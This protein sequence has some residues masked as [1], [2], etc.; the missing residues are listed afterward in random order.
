VTKK[1]RRTLEQI[2][3]ALPQIECKRKC[4]ES[5]GPIG[6]FP[7][8]VEHI[9]QSGNLIP[10]A[11]LHPAWGKIACSALLLN[12]KCNIYAHRPLICRLF[13]LVQKMQCPHGCQPDR[14]LTDQESIWLMDELKALKHGNPYYTAHL[15]ALKSYLE[16]L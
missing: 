7:I 8:E 4:Q 14:W 12:G 16:G 9:H 1:K 5:C 6:L 15:E 13:G 3:E 2:Y 11:Q 10:S